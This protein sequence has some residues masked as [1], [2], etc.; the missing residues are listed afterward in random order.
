MSESEAPLRRSGN[1]PSSPHVDR[2][3]TEFLARELDSAA[4]L[5]RQGIPTRSRGRDANGGGDA[6]LFPILL[7]YANSVLAKSD[8]PGELEIGEP[9]HPFLVDGIRQAGKTDSMRRE[10]LTFERMGIK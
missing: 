4:A 6:T 1:D 8:S 10:D 9:H 5:R 2:L 7:M 3:D